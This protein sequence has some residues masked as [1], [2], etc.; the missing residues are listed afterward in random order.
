MQEGL[1]GRHFHDLHQLETVLKQIP[2][3]EEAEAYV[4]YA[5]GNKLLLTAEVKGT[6]E[7]DEDALKAYVEAQCGKAHVPAEIIWK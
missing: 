3:V 7:Q 2:G 6:M 1:T 5:E 4:R